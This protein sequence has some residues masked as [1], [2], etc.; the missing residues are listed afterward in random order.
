MPFTQSLVWLQALPQLPLAQFAS[1]QTVGVPALAHVPAPLHSLGCD[2][3]AVA[4]TV[5]HDTPAATFLQVPL[6]HLPVVPQTSVPVSSVQVSGSVPLVATSE[7]VPMPLSE[8]FWQ[9][10]H[11]ATLQQLPST[12]CCEV[13]SALPPHASPSAFRPQ[14][15]P[16]Q[17]FGFTQSA[18]VSVQVVLHVLVKLLHWNVPHDCA[19]TGTHAPAP[20]QLDSGVCELPTQLSVPQVVAELAF[21]Q[22]PPPSHFPV[23]PQGGAA[24]HCVATVGKPPAP[25]LLQVPSDPVNEQ[26]L[27]VSVHAVL[28]QTPSAQWPELHCASVVQLCPLPVRPQLPPVH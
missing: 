6:S 3:T 26:L 17:R 5:P 15:P 21:W 4:Q 7:Q 11:A 1:R 25:T 14:L 8:H 27:Q 28:Q 16:M 19:D 24:T 22:A 2:S 10:P 18:A 23:N 12:Q 20:S 9:V 13:H